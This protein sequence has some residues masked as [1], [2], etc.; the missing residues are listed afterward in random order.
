[1][2]E[3]RSSECQDDCANKKTHVSSL[4]Q[5]KQQTKIS[6]DT[7]DF[8]SP[9]IKEAVDAT[10]NPSLILQ[11][12]KVE[13]INEIC[14]NIVREH[15]NSYKK[16]SINI[17]KDSTLVDDICDEFI[18]S[19]GTELAN[20]LKGRVS[21]EVDANLSF[22]RQASFDKAKKFIEMYEKK[23]ISR[24]RIYI[25]LAGTPEC[26]EAVRLLEKENINC[27][28]TLIFSFYQAVYAAQ[29]NA[30]LISP[31]VGR[32]YDYY[33]NK[34]QDKQELV[35]KDNTYTD[36]GVESVSKIYEHFKTHG[37]K[38][39]VMGASFRNIDQIKS[40]NGCD[41]LTISPALLKK[42]DED[43][44]ELK[45]KLSEDMFKTEDK[46]VEKDEM[47]E[48]KQ[49][50]WELACDP[51]ANEKLAEGIRLFDADMKKL[52]ADICRRIEK[53][54]VNKVKL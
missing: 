7:S 46:K 13:K 54:A 10:T 5:L 40:L 22:D 33:L 36:K 34:E 18:V 50:R 48:E 37:Y 23:G 17:S 52:K 41:K 24:D 3:K 26:I 47:I 43:D 29:A 53:H 19:V 49:L 25:K 31:F 11:S 42:L 8:T 45:V 39:I 51:M 12:L 38:T 16:E 14:E 4:E 20:R 21:T 30:S 44:V 6:I 32:I 35:S 15:V 1:M 2:S 9:Q 27:N 28:V